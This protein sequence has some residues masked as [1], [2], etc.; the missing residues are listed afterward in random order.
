MDAPDTGAIQEPIDAVYL[1]VDGSNPDLQ[2]KMDCFRQDSSDGDSVGSRRFRDNGELKHSLRSLERHAPWIRKVFIVCSGEPPAW[3]DTGHPD[4]HPV[5][6]EEIFPDPTVLPVFNSCAIELNLHR[7]PGL[8]RRFLYL[9]DDFFWGRDISLEWFLP[10]DGPPRFFFE[11]NPIFYSGNF[12]TVHD[13]A[14]AYTLRHFPWKGPR[15]SPALVPSRT[16]WRKLLGMSPLRYMPAHVPQLYDREALYNLESRFPAEFQATRTHRFRAQDDFT[17]RIMYA[18]DGLARRQLQAVRFEWNSPDFIFIR[19]W[20]DLERTRK[21]LA[22]LVRRSPRFI[23]ANDDVASEEPNPPAILHW[24]EVMSRHWPLP[25]R[26]ER[27][28]VL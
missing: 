6:H 16:N 3:L 1:W 26:F 28:H 15:R 12:R 8:S 19:L 27:R 24:K 10:A 17:L 4:L 9:N 7:I 20:D 18:Y 23:C 14:C 25:S 13:R 2:A 21:S 11:S 22:R 5:R